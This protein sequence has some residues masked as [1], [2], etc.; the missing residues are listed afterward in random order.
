LQNPLT[1]KCLSGHSQ[2]WQCHAGAPT[3]CS[4]CER[5]RKE[6]V[7]RAQRTLEEKLKW[8]ERTQT[9]LKEVAKVEEDMEQIAQ[10]MKDARLDSEQRAVLTQKRMDLAAAKE[11]ANRTQDSTSEEPL[12]ISNNNHPKTRNLPVQKSSP[13]SPGS[14]IS[15]PGQNL[16]LREHIEAAVKHNQSPSKTE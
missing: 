16:N 5:D 11:R 12:G 1:Q 4:K 3:A 15:T 8:D 13:T 7:K 9:H 6:A 2:S 10:S 14:A